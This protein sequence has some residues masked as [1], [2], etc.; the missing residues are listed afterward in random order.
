MADH[1]VVNGKFASDN[2]R[3]TASKSSWVSNPY[4]EKGADNAQTNCI[5]C[6]QHGGTSKSTESILA[7]RDRFPSSSRTKLR[8]NFPT[9]YFWAMTSAPERLAG[10]I[11]DQVKHYDQ[12]DR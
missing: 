7:A 8:K 11:E 4:L 6:H 9:D 10:V 5:G 12:V 1:F 3:Q 2:P